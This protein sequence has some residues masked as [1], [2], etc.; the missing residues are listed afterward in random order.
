MRKLLRI[1]RNLSTDAVHA[2]FPSQLFV[3]HHS[4]VSFGRVTGRIGDD[5]VRIAVED[6]GQ[7]SGVSS[8]GE[9]V[10]ARFGED[11][12]HIGSRARNTLGKLL[13]KAGGDRFKIG[14][15]HV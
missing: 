12:G 13:V 3:L 2:H 10:S 8:P 1:L 7:R 4:K 11:L 5:E 6:V 14:K 9:D 15:A